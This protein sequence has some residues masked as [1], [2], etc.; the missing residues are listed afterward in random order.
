MAILKIL[1]IRPSNGN[2]RLDH[3]LKTILQRESA[4]GLSDPCKS[5]PTSGINNQPNFFYFKK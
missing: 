1:S 4:S 5:G 3:L 2:V